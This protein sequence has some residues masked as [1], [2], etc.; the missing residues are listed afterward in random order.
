[1]P[2]Q[3]LLGEI[4]IQMRQGG[5]QK[6][7]GRNTRGHKTQDA[8]VEKM[9]VESKEPR[10]TGSVCKIRTPN[11][12]TSAPTPRFF[13]QR[14]YAPP[15]RSNTAPHFAQCG[16]ARKPASAQ[17]GPPTRTPARRRLTTSFSGSRR[18][19]ASA[20]SCTITVS[21]GAADRRRPQARAR[22]AVLR[23]VVQGGGVPCP[24]GHHPPRVSFVPE[25]EFVALEGRWEGH[26][27]YPAQLDA[28]NM[29]MGRGFRG[30]FFVFVIPCPFDESRLFQS[31]I[32]AN[33]LHEDHSARW[34]P[35]A[36]M[37]DWDWEAPD[38]RCEVLPGDDG[39]GI[40]VPTEENTLLDE[41]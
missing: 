37:A 7:S 22:G 33:W 2:S 16:T 19:T 20:P 27:S 12:P 8:G 25:A 24:E 41:R 26:D 23:T 11:S 29:A 15:P 10:E 28:E 36:A 39:E 21:A 3:Q 32:I 13:P 17:T 6:H 9:V 1:M 35:T 18:A 34:I 5:L 38:H 14:P 4:V 30:R 31:Y 40:R